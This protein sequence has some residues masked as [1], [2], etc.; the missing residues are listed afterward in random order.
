MK[1]ILCIVLVI[2][3]SVSLSACGNKASSEFKD[4]DT[5]LNDVKNKGN[6]VEK[7]IDD[8]HLKRLDDLSK[9]DMTDENKKEF[10]NLQNRLN[11]QLVPKM[12][13]YEKAAKQLPAESKETK[14]LKS[15]YLDVVK[16]KKSA[17]N[18]LTSFVDLYNQSIKANED[19]LDYTKLF[20]KNRSQVEKNMKKANN[21]G[22]TADVNNFKHKLEQNNKDLRQTA[23]N[24]LE[25]SDSNKVKHAINEEIMPL[26]TTEIKDLN[27][28]EIKDGYVNDARKNAIEMYYSL[29]NYYE[30][31]EETIENSEKLKHIDYDKL[32]QE[33]KDIEQ[34]DKTF[35]KRYSEL[36]HS[37]N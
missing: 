24:A 11:S 15:S 23:E 34:F 1:K 17:I 26:I 7:V 5:S 30:T 10:N 9:T 16:Q 29:Q 19:I 20:E 13:E 18:E 32:P 35:D 12:D 25:S 36:K 6:E 33:G 37:Y 31:R 28:A 2:C 14:E 8:I 21:A 3:F 4:F 27:K 22:E